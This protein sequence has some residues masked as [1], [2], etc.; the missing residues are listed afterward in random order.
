MAIATVF[1]IPTNLEPAFWLVIFLLCAYL[2]AKSRRDQYF[3]HG[4]FVSLV[5][6]VWI[7]SAHLLLANAYLANHAPEAEMLKSMP[8]I[9]LRLM[10]VVTGTVIGVTSGLVLGL[11]SWVASKLVKPAV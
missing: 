8:G 11:F 10:M 6:C 3:L 2:I 9:P 7:V 1:W 4:M 5:N